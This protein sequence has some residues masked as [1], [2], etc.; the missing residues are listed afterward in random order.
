VAEAVSAR[1]VDAEFLEAVARCARDLDRSHNDHRGDEL[2]EA[3]V[4]LDSASKRLEN[5]LDAIGDCDDRERRKR[6]VA[7]LDDA[8]MEI[9][10]VQAQVD[11][12]RA[13]YAAAENSEEDLA[14]WRNLV[15]DLPKLLMSNAGRGRAALQSLLEGPLRATPIEVDGENR[16]VIS[17][18][19]QPSGLV[20]ND[21]DPN[22]IRTRVA[23][24]TDPWRVRG[25]Y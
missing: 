13:Q 21:G 18:L 5:Y 7:R 24:M 10:R 8:E 14:V 17:W 22:G 4:R 11:G 23:W 20:Q 6:L 3:E 15:A 12:L 2:R 1:L 9:A 19:L 25:T 16:F